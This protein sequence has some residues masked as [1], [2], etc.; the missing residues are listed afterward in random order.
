MKIFTITLCLQVLLSLSIK[1]QDHKVFG[2]TSY[3]SIKK[4]YVDDFWTY[5]KDFKDSLNDGTWK[6]YKTSDSSKKN[7][8]DYL[9]IEGTFKNKKRDGTF[10]Y[11]RVVGKGGKTKK[12]T[13]LILNY[14]KGVLHGE[15]INFSS[16][17]RTYFKGNYND[18]K[19][20]GFFLLYYP[21]GFN[22]IQKVEYYDKGELQQWV[23]YNKNGTIRKQG[24]G[25]KD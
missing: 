10:T 5:K 8:E 3:A 2:D 11:Y 7:I 14:K 19:K 13:E 4:V 21:H 25:E 15:V 18:G 17:D 6:Y 9:E 16:S 1:G 24:Y 23:E 12:I 22:I 20:D